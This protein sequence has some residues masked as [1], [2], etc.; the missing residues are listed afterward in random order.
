MKRALFCGL[1]III[2]YLPALA[3][4]TDINRY[5]LFTGFD[6]MISP[7]RNLTARGF[8][9]DF[10]VT[11]KPWLGLGGD[12]GAMGDGIISGAGTINGSETVFAPILEQYQINPSL[13]NVPFRSSTYT[14]AAGPQ[15]YLRKWSKVTFLV[16]PGLG[17]IH[18]T[19]NINLTAVA[20]IFQQLGIP[21]PNS[22]QVD[23]QLFF[24]VGGGFDLNLSRRVGV[25]FATDW[26]NTHLFSNLLTPRQ[27]YV[28]FSLGPTFRWGKLK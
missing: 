23:T 6:Y 20:P 24:G 26:V 22:H 25:R 7:A 15:F 4:Q 17:G 3:Q 27:N 14:F 19:A 11:V 9:G 5:T 12:F 10:G 16:R 21:V 28:R 1:A 18:E 8:E 2:L 13:V